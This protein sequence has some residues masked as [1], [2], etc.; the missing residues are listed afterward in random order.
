[1]EKSYTEANDSCV[2]HP[3]LSL[4]IGNNGVLNKK[5]SIDENSKT[6]S[7]QETKCN[8]RYHQ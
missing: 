8:I 2:C 7:F 1:M 4:K 3:L 6:T 5:V